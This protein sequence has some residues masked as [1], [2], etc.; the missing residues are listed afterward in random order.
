MKKQLLLSL[1]LFLAGSLMAAPVTVLSNKKVA[2]GYY[3]KLNETATELTYLGG[4]SERYAAEATAG[5]YVTNE[6]LKLV[7]YKNGTRTELYPHGKD[8]N[9]ICASISPDGQKILFKTSKGIGVCDMNGNALANL[10]R[11][12]APVW[13][14][15]DYVVATLEENDGHNFTG[16]AV[17]ILSLD[18]QLKQ[19]LTDK[20]EI[21]MCPTVDYTT[22]QIA[23]HDF[24]GNIHLMQISLAEKAIAKRALPS[25]RKV[26]GV[27]PKAMRRLQNATKADFK[28]FKIY[29]NPGHGGNG[30]DDRGMSGWLDETHSGYIFWESQSNL[31]K[32]LH[33]DTLL[34]NLGFQTKM[35]RVLNRE[36]DDKDLYDIVVEA[37]T[38][39][40]DF[41]LSIHTNAGGP[42]N[43]TLQLFRGYTPGDTRTYSDMPTAENNKKAYEITTLMGNL[44]MSNKIATWSKSTPT[45][46]GD[47]TFARDIMGWS[48]GYG[49]LRWLDVPG[50][51][52]EGAMHDYFPETYR[53]MNMD[54]K[55]QEA[56]YFMKTFCSYYMDYKQ[57]K[58]VL[59]GQVR[60]AYRKQTFP[61]IKRIKG[62]RDEQIPVNRA[63]VELLQNGQVIKTYTTDTC[64]NG[65]FFFWDLEPGEYTVRV[66]EGKYELRTST[67][68]E[69]ESYYY[70]KESE[71]LTV[72]ADEITHVD[73]MLDAQRST[74]PEV[75][76]YSPAITA[77]NIT[78]SVNVSETVVLNFNWDM[79]AEETEAAFSISPAVEGTLTWENSYRTLR[80][81]PTD[82][83]AVGTEYTVTLAKT[84]C[85]PDTNWENTMAE[86][87]TFKFR[88]KFRGEISLVQS[89]PV[90]D[91]QDVSTNPSFILIFDGNIKATTANKKAFKLMQGDEEV[92]LNA[93]SFSISRCDGSMTFEPTNE[94][95]PNTTY[96]LV[97]D[98]TLVD[99]DKIYFG[100]TLEIPFTT[101]ATAEAEG[102]MVDAMETAS[103]KYNS[104]DSEGVKTASVLKY[105]TKK[106]FET[107]SNQ[108]KYAF[109]AEDGYV[110]YTY[111][112]PALITDANGNCRL[113][114][115]VFGDFSE[116]EL[117]AVWNSEGDI[118]YTSFGVIDFAGWKFLSA[119]MSALPVDMAYQFMGLR[120]KRGTGFLS[121]NGFICV[122][123]M[124]FVA[125]PNMST[126]IDNVEVEMVG[127]QKVVE[128]EQVIIIKDG[129]RYNVLGTQVK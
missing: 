60:D 43:Y 55:W 118:K 62:S 127:V 80:F 114:M 25:I 12:T 5:T 59:A 69:Q 103:F 9:Y 37:N 119:D 51:I 116:N 18:G 85:H 75:I 63:T 128:N 14:G 107:A 13:Y 90:K 121:S 105:T 28:D 101:V 67:M 78:D 48:N 117:V 68:S 129:V 26:E 66:P 110:T 45:I 79:K 54:Y 24:S 100:K 108:F 125:D 20:A 21:A 30:S 40:A 65:V 34:R 87:F 42:S 74:R 77:E 98:E 112:N 86:D 122:D 70:G 6:D 47:K 29:I 33:L 4:E 71:V 97:I 17:M 2:K 83:L 49:V 56:W 7:L 46:A 16:G 92:A 35:S 73:M 15:N 81:T 82:G 19:Q 84:A 23:Y 11:Y 52:S 1:A 102:T 88:T 22:G 53:L 27:Q 95:L 64:Y 93:K 72:K 44:Q 38:F 113:G 104:D 58:G 89:Y 99:V 96:R 39:G 31:D 106:L 109:N 111:L 124:M 76:G 120:L 32:G 10:G 61:A 50:T 94:L 126:A 57:P 8:I 115:Y 91:Q 41:M 3:P 123:N 36:E